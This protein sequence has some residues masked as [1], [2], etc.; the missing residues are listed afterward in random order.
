MRRATDTLLRAI[1]PDGVTR[2][3][4]APELKPGDGIGNPGRVEQRDCQHTSQTQSSVSPRRA[5]SLRAIA[6]AVPSTS[7]STRVPVDEL[8]QGRRRIVAPAGSF[9]GRRCDRRAPRPRPDC[10]SR[11]AARRPLPT[12]S[13]NQVSHV[14]SACGI[15]TR[16]RLVEQDRSRARASARARW[17][18]AAAAFR[19]RAGRITCSGRT[20][21][22]APTRCST[23]SW[24]C[25]R[26]YR[27][28]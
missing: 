23:A 7:I 5:P 24:G 16:G 17:P 3:M 1:A 25:G 11:P 13:S 12:R 28:A 14:T 22:P 10:A 26:P 8:S 9:S 15:E 2:R 4:R 19:E 18:A 6:S 27:R 20:S 21:R